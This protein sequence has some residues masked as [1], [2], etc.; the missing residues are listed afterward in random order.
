MKFIASE[1]FNNAI[2]DELRNMGLVNDNSLSGQL[3]T[4]NHKQA[5]LATQL[6]I[7]G[8]ISETGILHDTDKLVLYGLIDKRQASKAHRLYARHHI[9]VSKTDRD[10]EDCIIDYECARYT[11]PD[12]P[13]NAYN[14]VMKYT[15]D[16]YNIL[17]PTLIRLGLNSEINHD[18]DFDHWEHLKSARM[19]YLID[20][21]ITEIKK[22]Y[23]DVKNFGV[24]I[25]LKNFYAK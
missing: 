8:N 4:L 23:S 3:Y 21:N 16:K 1:E 2:L 17:R 9:Q 19:Q 6:A 24:E 20:S 15:P 10:L 22:L 12:K 18:I 11:K 7:I 25:G 5:Y 14:T 13:L